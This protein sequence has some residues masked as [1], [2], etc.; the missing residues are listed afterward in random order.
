MVGINGIGEYT[1]SLRYTHLGLPIMRAFLN[2]GDFNFFMVDWSVGAETLNYILARGR[3][4]EG[5][6]EIT[7]SKK[8]N[9]TIFNFYFEQSGQLWLDSLTF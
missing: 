7:I 6:S 4:N 8:C 5:T 2:R 3:V 9:E 1:T